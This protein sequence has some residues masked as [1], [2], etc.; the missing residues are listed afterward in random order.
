MSDINLLDRVASAEKVKMNLLI[1]ATLAGINVKSG[2]VDSIL[3]IWDSYFD[4][5]YPKIS[6][7]RRST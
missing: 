3:C 2:T 6:S 5:I 1:D 7:E 4:K